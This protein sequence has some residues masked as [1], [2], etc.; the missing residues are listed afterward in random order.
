[1]EQPREFDPFMCM[2]SGGWVRL[3][4]SGRGPGQGA[5]LESSLGRP[6]CQGRDFPG[7]AP[8]SKIRNHHPWV[9]GVRASGQEGL[10]QS[11]WKQCLQKGVFGQ[12][13]RG[14]SSLWGH[15]GQWTE[16]SLGIF[17]FNLLRKYTFFWEHEKSMS[18]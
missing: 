8:G 18:L 17:L 14:D 15:S 13:P 10:R 7:V 5:G 2:R 4:A 6:I 16:R 1:M 9:W 11:L 12:Y 3:G